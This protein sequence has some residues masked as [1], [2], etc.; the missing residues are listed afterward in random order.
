[1]IPINKE[2]IVIFLLILLALWVLYPFMEGFDATGTEFAQLGRPRYGLRGNPLR[3][4]DIANYYMRPDLRIRISESGGK[5][6]ESN[7]SPMAEGIKD[8]HKIPCPANGYDSIDV[9]FQCGKNCPKKMIIPDIH[10]H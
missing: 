5:M 3:Q 4:I 9:C 8:C 6:W 1:M 10:P 2:V 7:N